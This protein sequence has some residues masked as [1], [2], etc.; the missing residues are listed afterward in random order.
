MWRGAAARGRRWACG[1]GCRGG[2]LSTRHTKVAVA[3]IGERERGTRG[4]KR[5]HARVRRKGGSK[6]VALA[7]LVR[8][9][10]GYRAPTV[11]TGENWRQQNGRR[12]TRWTR[13]SQ[14]AADRAQAKERPRLLHLAL[15]F[16]WRVQLSLGKGAKKR[17]ERRR[18]RN[19]ATARSSPFFRLCPSLSLSLCSAVGRLKLPSPFFFSLSPWP[20]LFTDFRQGKRTKEKASHWPQLPLLRAV[21]LSAS[22]PRLPLPRRFPRA[23]WAQ[24]RAAYLPRSIAQCRS[25]S[26]AEGKV[27]LLVRHRLPLPPSPSPPRLLRL[28]TAQAAAPAPDTAWEEA[29]GR[30][31]LL[32]PLPRLRRCA[33]PR[34]P[35]DGIGLCKTKCF[36]FELERSGR[37]HASPAPEFG[38]RE[39]LVPAVMPWPSCRPRLHLARAPF[40]TTDHR[41]SEPDP[42]PP[43]AK[44]AS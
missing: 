16:L 25:H 36:K 31:S 32:A 9:A 34:R 28:R 20:S 18:E 30:W 43:L 40:Q 11:S 39:R 3:S 33:T 10:R 17:D 5:P 42:R 21:P 44:R 12:R 1:S 7:S 26:R 14:A 8:A 41:G 19:A 4:R 27:L 29:G 15:L 2:R 13:K 35:F 37:P 23:P 6:R 24:E 38:T 22:S